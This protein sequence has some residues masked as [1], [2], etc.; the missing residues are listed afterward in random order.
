MGYTTKRDVH[1]GR[2]RGIP[3]RR[4]TVWGKFSGFKRTTKTNG[5]SAGTE[6]VTADHVAGPAR[7]R[8]N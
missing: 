6:R 1:S 3:V 7:K 8:N 2:R 4:S 5:Q